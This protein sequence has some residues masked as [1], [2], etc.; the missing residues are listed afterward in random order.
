MK[1]YLFW[2]FFVLKAVDEFLRIQNL[3]NSNARNWNIAVKFLMARRFDVERAI[4][5]YNE[6]EV[7]H[8]KLSISFKI[9]KN[10]L[11]KIQTLSLWKNQ[12]KVLRK[13]EGLD[14]I[15]LNDPDFIDDLNTGKFTVLVIFLISSTSI[16][17][18]NFE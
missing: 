5:L 6:H 3:S 1:K 16:L 18:I 17:F 2:I 10:F 4:K 14:F 13:R 7:T 8:W 15:D 11:F 9:L 12:N